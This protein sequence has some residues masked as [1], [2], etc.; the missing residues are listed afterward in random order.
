MSFGGKN[1]IKGGVINPRWGLYIYIYI[2]MYY[3]YTY[4]ILL[5]KPLPLN[6][7]A[8][9]A[10]QPLSWCS[11]SLSSQGFIFPSR[12]RQPH[13]N[14]V[15]ALS[16]WPSTT[17]AGRAVTGRLSQPWVLTHISDSP[18]RLHLSKGAYSELGFPIARRHQTWH[19]CERATSAPAEG[20]ANGLDFE[21]HCEFPLRTLRARKWHV[22]G[23]DHFEGELR[24]FP[25]K[26]VWTSVCLR[27]WRRDG[28]WRQNTFE[29]AVL[30]TPIPWDPLSSL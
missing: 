1:K 20:P 23:T 8:E 11:G 29:P 28:C 4:I 21:C 17:G 18:S 3:V 7:A 14:P 30:T 15:N 5:G 9:T 6:P 27:V 19:F 26:G 2:Y 12:K 10:L 24:G 22:Y 16:S 13:T 25:R